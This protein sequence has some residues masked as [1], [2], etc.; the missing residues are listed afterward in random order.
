MLG[1]ARVQPNRPRPIH[2]RDPNIVEIVIDQQSPAPQEIHVGMP[3]LQLLDR[4]R[5][6]LLLSRPRPPA[7]VVPAPISAPDD[8][9]VGEGGKVRAEDLLD[10][11]HLRR[12]GYHGHVE[13]GVGR[14]AEEMQDLGTNVRGQLGAR[15]V[16]LAA[17]VDVDD[18]LVKVNRKEVDLD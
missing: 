13:G 7:L 15:P 1:L 5:D 6:E 14:G 18:G 8:D 12:E 2:R 11:A 9:L 4:T 3:V 10:E 16:P 17:G